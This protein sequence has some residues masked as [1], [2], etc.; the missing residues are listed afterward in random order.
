MDSEF[1]CCLIILVIGGLAA[2]ALASL[3]LGAAKGVNLT[4]PEL[5][6][7][8]SRIGVWGFAIVIAVDQ[9]GVAQ[10]IVN[11]L[12]TAV[13]GALALAI[14]L[15]LGLGGRETAGEILKKWFGP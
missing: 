7:T 11:T 10:N 1:N 3:V 9:I 8:I 5:L 4:N 14:G 2:N 6:A 13:V 15:A 12:F